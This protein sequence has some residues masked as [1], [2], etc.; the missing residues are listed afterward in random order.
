[1]VARTIYYLV[2]IKMNPQILN[3]KNYQKELWETP[4]VK[5]T[6]KSK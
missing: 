6:M 3:Q 2:G 5:N 4:R 1:M